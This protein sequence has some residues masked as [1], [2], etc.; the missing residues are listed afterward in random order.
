MVFKMKIKLLIMYSAL[1]LTCAIDTQKMGRVKR[2]TA[3]TNI[4]SNYFTT[5]P[6]FKAKQKPRIHLPPKPLPRV[7]LSN[8][9]P[10]NMQQPLNAVHQ[11]QS[12]SNIHSP[13]PVP[14][15]LGPPIRILPTVNKSS[16]KHRMLTFQKP[17]S[18][19]AG[20]S[21]PQNQGKGKIPAPL[22]VGGGNQEKQQKRMPPPP[23][24]HNVISKPIN[25]KKITK[26]DLRQTHQNKNNM[27]ANRRQSFSQLI[28][29]PKVRGCSFI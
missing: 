20:H 17:S 10:K 9:P 7:E 13:R 27:N 23:V 14:I 22:L 3:F 11:Q 26:K 28:S 19:K 12:S 1:T 24:V 8:L 16:I 6:F 18:Y 2:K 5:D 15:K 25:Q 29:K 21:L 4:I